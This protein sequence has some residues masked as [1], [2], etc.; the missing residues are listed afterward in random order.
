M[1]HHFATD[2][3][4][5]ARKQRGLLRGPR[6]FVA[7]LHKKGKSVLDVIPTATRDDSPFFLMVRDVSRSQRSWPRRQPGCASPPRGRSSTKSS[8]RVRASRPSRCRHSEK[9]EAPTDRREQRR[10]SLHPEKEQEQEC[11]V[12]QRAHHRVRVAKRWRSARA[13]ARQSPPDIRVDLFIHVAVEWGTSGLHHTSRICSL[14]NLNMPE[15][16]CRLRRTAPRARQ[17]HAS[18]LDPRSTARTAEEAI[19]PINDTIKAT[20]RTDKQLAL[21]PERRTIDR[22]PARVQIGSARSRLAVMGRGRRVCVDPPRRCM[23]MDRSR[24]CAA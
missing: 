4:D 22:V 15:W 12:H 1:N 14:R 19:W 2:V 6:P 13:S 5:T 7:T 10:A 8:V 9:R 16:A 23:A 20:M 21:L 3:T 18:T 24:S 17:A 11:S